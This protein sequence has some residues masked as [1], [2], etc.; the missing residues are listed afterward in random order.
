MTVTPK[1]LTLIAKEASP[2]EINDAAWAEGMH[3]LR[4]S[5][6]RL[7]LEGVTSYHEMLKTTFEN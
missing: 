1:L 7:V 6:Q 3:T 5:A 2:E 4:Q